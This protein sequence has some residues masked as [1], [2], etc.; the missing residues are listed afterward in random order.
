MSTL[1]PVLTGTD[2]M[3]LESLPSA[4]LPAVDTVSGKVGSRDWSARDGSDGISNFATCQG[5]VEMQIE[6]DETNGT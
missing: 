3:Q 5:V 2:E 6:G 1:K 4:L